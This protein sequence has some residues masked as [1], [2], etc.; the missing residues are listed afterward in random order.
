MRFEHRNSSA[1]NHPVRH[2]IILHNDFNEIPREA[3]QDSR[4]YYQIEFRRGTGR[5]PFT[6]NSLWRRTT[7]IPEKSLENWQ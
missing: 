5:R 4:T 2:A 7:A 6:Q 3:E 1:R